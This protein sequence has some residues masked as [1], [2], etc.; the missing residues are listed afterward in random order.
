MGISRREA[1][2]QY[3]YRENTFISKMSYTQ[4]ITTTT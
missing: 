1:K 3:G 4:G 2:R